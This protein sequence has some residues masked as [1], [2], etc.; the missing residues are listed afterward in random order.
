MRSLSALVLCLGI[1]LLSMVDGRHVTAMAEQHNAREKPIWARQAT[2]LDLGCTSHPQTI[3]SPDH[4]SSAK[5]VCTNHKGSDPTLALRIS[6]PNGNRYEMPLDEGAHELLWAPNSESFFVDG[7]ETAYAGFFASVYQIEH[8]TGVRKVTVTSTA[9]KD[10]V[11]SFPPCKAYNRDEVT[12][13]QIAK[14]PE[15]NMSALAW[16]D[17]SLAIYVFA[18]V[19]CSSSY[20]GIMCQV[21]GYE[22]SVPA[23]RILKRLSAL[24]VKQ[25]WS[26]Y[27]A[28]DIR[29]PE[30]PK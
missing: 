30:R 1:S 5:V 25:Q 11:S 9:Q 24:Q 6:T 3:T 12:C 18:E 7:G 2:V 28:W 14:H 4:Q 23:G 16:T 27:A 13:A 17:D 19:P 10:M 8:P 29:V 22:L 21:L 26:H 15:Y 20:G